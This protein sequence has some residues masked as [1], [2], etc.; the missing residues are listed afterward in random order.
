MDDVW[1]IWV[2]RLLI[3]GFPQLSTPVRSPQNTNLADLGVSRDCPV[4]ACCERLQPRSADQRVN[5]AQGSGDARTIRADRGAGFVD[6][7]IIF[8]PRGGCGVIVAMSRWNVLHR[9]RSGGIR[10]GGGRMAVAVAA[11]AVTVAALTTGALGAST[12]SAAPGA[13]A[14]G[15]ALPVEFDLA[16]YRPAEPTRFRSLAYSDNGRS[17]FTTGRWMCQIGPQYRYVGC[18]GRPATGPPNALGVAIAGDQSGPWWVATGLGA[19]TYRFGSTAGFRPP[20]LGVGQRVTI[21]G[22]TCTVPRADAVACRTGARAVIYTPGWHKFF[23]PSG[24]R[25]HSGNPA[26]RYLPPRLQYWNQLPA[27][28][29][30]PA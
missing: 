14:S 26:P 6:P 24:D 16:R 9:Y 8:R 11:A 25:A 1:S 28:S 12:A 15:P 19:P 22:V 5:S 10:S 7:A 18:Q 27:R 21:A 17:F 29:S 30:T 20:V 4:R 13:A 3:T 23:Y 2:F